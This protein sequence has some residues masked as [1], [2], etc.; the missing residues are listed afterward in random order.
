MTTKDAS[1]LF[2]D[3]V[4]G[5]RADP[6]ANNPCSNG[7]TCMVVGDSFQCNCPPNFKGPRCEGMSF[8]GFF[9]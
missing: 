1:I 8:A 7:G 9:I 3:R 2:P 5:G 4:S 6:C